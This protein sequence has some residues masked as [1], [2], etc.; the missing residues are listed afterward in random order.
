MFANA[1]ELSCMT[2]ESVFALLS[3]W[4]LAHPPPQIFLQV[5]MKMT[6]LML[7]GMIIMMPW[8][9]TQSSWDGIATLTNRSRWTS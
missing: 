2:C 1:L 9:T 8:A 7:F 4:A 5:L 3:Y 6:I